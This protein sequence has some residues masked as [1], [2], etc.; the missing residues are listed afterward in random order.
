MG[1][2]LVKRF[3]RTVSGIPT[4]VFRNR[5]T[6]MPA[7][8]ASN[9]CVNPAYSSILPALQRPYE[10]VTRHHSRHRDARP[11]LRPATKV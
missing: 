2:A 7:P 11:K 8:R 1:A 6:G 5:L 10:N 9:D 4:A 3:R